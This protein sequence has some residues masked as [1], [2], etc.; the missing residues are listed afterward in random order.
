VS[1][2]GIRRLLSMLSEQ[3]ESGES[4]TLDGMLDGDAV[5]DGVRRRIS[6][7]LAGATLSIETA[8]GSYAETALALRIREREREVERLFRAIREADDAG[9]QA[10]AQAAIGEQIAVLNEIEALKRKRYDLTR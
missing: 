4:P 8:R 1:D 10:T 6:A 7:A 3:V 2:E 5:P 9:D